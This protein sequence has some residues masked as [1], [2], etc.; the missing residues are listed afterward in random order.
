MP[1]F[2]IENQASG[3]NPHEDLNFDESASIIISHV[4]KGIEIAKKNN[5][6]EQIIDF[7]RT[8]HGTTKT[9]YF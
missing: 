7:I 8:H 9:N 2:F 4:I 6:P 1:I 3:I 5:L